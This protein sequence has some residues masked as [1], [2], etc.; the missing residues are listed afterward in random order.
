M[1][2][3][4]F[5]FHR[6]KDSIVGKL[7]KDRWILKNTLQHILEYKDKLKLN[8]QTLIKQTNFK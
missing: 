7:E 3:G 8:R 1:F 5:L 6:F 2:L 4:L